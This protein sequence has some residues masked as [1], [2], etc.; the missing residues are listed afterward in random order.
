MWVLCSNPLS[1][2]V[3]GLISLPLVQISSLA[4]FEHHAEP[5]DAHPEFASRR[6]V[7]EL[8]VLNRAP[9]ALQVAGSLSL[10]SGR[11]VVSHGMLRL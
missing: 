10:R 1:L 6:C 11:G 9:V 2:R 8:D 5:Q 4:F 3:R 7:L